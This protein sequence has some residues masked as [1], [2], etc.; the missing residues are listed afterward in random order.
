VSA[1]R[2]RT[3]VASAVAATTLVVAAPASAAAPV[4]EQMVVFKNGSAKIG[5][6]RAS[7]TRIKVRGKSCAVGA[8]TPLAALVRGRVGTLA[9]TDYGSCGP[10]AR[11]AGGLYVRAIGRDAARGP[12]GWVYKVGNTAAPAG[13]ADPAGP[14]GNGPLRPGQRV[15]WFYCNAKPNVEGCQRTLEMKVTSTAGPVASVR[16]RGYDNA[17]AGIDIA[18]ATISEGTS[19]LA[20]TDASGSASM[21]LSPGRHTLVATKPG[22]VRSYPVEVGVR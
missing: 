1:R 15:T 7:A 10:R 5:K 8:G 2:A 13:A 11:D 20:T 6:V 14:F 3:L 16:V 21:I 9:F 17:G 12:S 4:V 19:A 22:L 18:G